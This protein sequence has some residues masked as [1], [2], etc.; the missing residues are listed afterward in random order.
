MMRI[1]DGMAEFCDGFFAGIG[2]GS[3]DRFLF[4]ALSDPQKP[5]VDA[6]CV[7]QSI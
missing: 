3:F 4:W 1:L 6:I 7:N 5:K 2:S